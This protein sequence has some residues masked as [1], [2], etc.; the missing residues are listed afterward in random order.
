MSS[1]VLSLAAQADLDAID[2]FTIEQFGLDQAVR[3]RERFKQ[4]FDLL[5]ES[6]LSGR[7]LESASPAG[8]PF[9]YWLI[10]GT[11]VIVYEPVENVIRV[12][13]VLHGAQHLI[14]ELM[15]DSGDA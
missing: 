14:R 12:A 1:I 8:R 4:A 5:V 3:L 15:R 2:S 7:Q 9:R 13:R 11:F 10:G 6:P